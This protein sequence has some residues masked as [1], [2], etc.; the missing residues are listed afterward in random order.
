MNDSRALIVRE[1]LFCF[2]Y[3]SKKFIE[4]RKLSIKKLLCFK[5]CGR[6]LD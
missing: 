5:F 4:E 3:Q 2:M 6:T 1:S